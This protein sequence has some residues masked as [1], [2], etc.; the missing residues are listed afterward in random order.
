MLN[1]Y[2]LIIAGLV[3]ASA[4]AVTLMGIGGYFLH[5]KILKHYIQ[6]LAWRQ[7]MNLV[8]SDMDNA[9]ANTHDDFDGYEDYYEED[10]GEYDYGDDFFENFDTEENK[11]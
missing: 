3:G 4:A 1:K 8:F 5:R 6:S 7:A 9:K 11:Q 2:N 10:D